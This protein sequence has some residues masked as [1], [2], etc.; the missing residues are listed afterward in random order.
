MEAAKRFFRQ[1]CPRRL[2]SAAHKNRPQKEAESTISGRFCYKRRENVLSSPLRFFVDFTDASCS[3]PE[4][5]FVF[6]RIGK[7]LSCNFPVGGLQW[8]KEVQNEFIDQCYFFRFSGGNASG[9]TD[10][11]KSNGHNDAIVHRF[12][13]QFCQR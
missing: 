7:H 4:L 5:F 8:A 13:D 2:L 11:H 3:V 10:L 12:A 1:T 6:L 9:S